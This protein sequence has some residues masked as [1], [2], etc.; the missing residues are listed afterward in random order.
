VA[1]FNF[2][3]VVG[4]DRAFLEV[5]EEA[6]RAAASDVPILISGESGTGKELFAQAIHNASAAAS[7]PFVAINVTAIPREL[8]ESE[9]FGYEGGSFTG[10]RATGR[11]GKFELVGRGTLLLDEIGDMPL[12]MQAKLLRVLQEKVLQRLGSVRDVRIRARIIATTHHDLEEAVKAGRFRLDLVHRL[13]VLHLRVPA[14][15]DHRA[16]V[17]RLVEHQL[18]NIEQHGR[19]KVGIAPH[20]LSAL[21]AYDWP[22]NVR[23]LVNMIE[24]EVSLLAP[25]ENVLSRVPPGILARKGGR[26]ADE[27]VPLA[28][29][30][31]RACQEAIVRFQGNIAAAA[32]ALGIAKG[33][34]YAKMKLYRLKAP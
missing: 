34:L 8:L 20:V 10:A 17:R 22:G 24:A 30:E 9:L 13:R 27:V 3:D 26:G 2:E 14:L 5:V 11:A 18:G 7:Q 21:E 29:L 1:R 4:E 12:E 16:D 23:E 28:E 6:R 31:R 32:R 33:T 19:R 25:G 15:R